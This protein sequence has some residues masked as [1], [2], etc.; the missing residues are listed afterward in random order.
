MAL[1]L[2]FAPENLNTSPNGTLAN[3]YTKFSD[4]TNHIINS[5]QSEDKV[6]IYFR[7]GT[8]YLLESMVLDNSGKQWPSCPIYLKPYYSDKVAIVTNSFVDLPELFKL[9]QM[10]NV[11][12]EGFA[13]SNKFTGITMQKCQSCNLKTLSI[14]NSASG[15]DLLDCFKCTIYG[16]EIFNIANSGFTDA[17]TNRKS[18][19]PQY[20][21]LSESNIYSCQI[22]AALSNSVGTKINYTQIH[23]CVSAVY[24]NGGNDNIIEFNNILNIPANGVYSNPDPTIRGNVIK[25][26]YF[27]N[28][29][30][31]VN[32]DYMLC[33][34]K[35]DSNVF[36]DCETPVYLGGGRDNVVQNNVINNCANSIVAESRGLTDCTSYFDPVSGI[37]VANLK[38]MPY[39]AVLWSK[40]YPELSKYLTDSPS[41]PKNN[42]VVYNYI[43]NTFNNVTADA[44]FG[45]APNNNKIA[46]NTEGKSPV[47]SIEINF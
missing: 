23:D 41:T 17:Y 16:C 3:P 47:Y 34:C 10:S 35:V 30:K 24:L 20:N 45:D 11:T 7:K 44:L 14:S 21:L 15:I 29:R 36:L 9:V 37:M 2:Y 22:G 4:V 42:T 12:I 8:Y 19:I 32:L 39:T 27:S 5:A 38:A 28:V 6:V 25:N 13:L 46:K 43:L 1:Y 31:A 18:L 33:G 26:N 40:K